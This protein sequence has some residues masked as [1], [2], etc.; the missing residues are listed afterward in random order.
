MRKGAA[1]DHI[2][3]C[4]EGHTEEPLLYRQYAPPT[5]DRALLKAVVMFSNEVGRFEG[6]RPMMLT[7]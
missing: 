2:V 4:T 6:N 7:I 5:G 1:R 3:V